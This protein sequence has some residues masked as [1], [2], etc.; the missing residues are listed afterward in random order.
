[1]E[2]KKYQLEK[3]ARFV[4]VFFCFVALYLFGCCPYIQIS[5]ERR[6]KM[7]SIINK[8]YEG[9]IQLSNQQKSEFILTLE[10]DPRYDYNVFATTSHWMKI[11][12]ASECSYPS[13]IGVK[14]VFAKTSLF[15][16]GVEVSGKYN[17]YGHEDTTTLWFST[18]SPEHHS[19]RIDWKN[20]AFASGYYIN[21][22]W[23]PGEQELTG[24]IMKFV[25]R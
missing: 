21:E 5:G 6:E 1:M 17:F 20:Y 7:L 9:T 12:F 10:H 19:F 2:W 14:G 22:E 18:R 16:P 15:L 11:A 24:K 13:S 23:K 8:T 25:S 4:C 3:M